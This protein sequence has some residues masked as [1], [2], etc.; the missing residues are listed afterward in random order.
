VLNVTPDS[1][2]DGGLYLDADAALARA[3]Q[4]L[5]EGVDVI[6]VGGASSRPR[7]TMYGEGA[8]V[9][10]AD[11]EIRRIA[12]IIRVLARELNARVSVD[13]TKAPVAAAAIAAGASYVNDVSGGASDELLSVVADSGAAYV[14]MHTRGAGEVSEPNTRYAD[15]VAD[16]CAELRVA[17]ARA[18]TFGIAR[19]R[20]WLDPGLGFAKTPAQ[21]L[22]L[23]AR[24]DALVALG[25][26]VLVGPS[27]KGF[28]ASA[29]PGPD[30]A[31]PAPAERDPGTAAAVTLA[32]WLG[33][34][35]VRVH[36][37]A[38]MR[39]ALLFATA[40]RAARTKKPTGAPP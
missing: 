22:E 23:L 33:A 2:S 12:P 4:M 9:M 36:E 19:D 24:T 13:T 27:R 11:E 10:P 35:A 3:K 30:G 18:E 8:A 28:I 38:P 25:L 39:Q 15:L 6:D 17:V 7:G 40:T 26:P 1:F 5:A 14:L 16:V 21:S 34:A 29:A 31:A 37:V 20:I 32:A